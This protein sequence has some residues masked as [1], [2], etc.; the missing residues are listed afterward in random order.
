[1]RRMGGLSSLM[2]MLPTAAKGV[3]AKEAEKK[4][5]QQEAII[6]SMT[7]A[8]R[9]KPALLNASRKRRIAAGAGVDVPAVNRLLK[10]QEQMAQVM[11]KLGGM[12]KKKLMRAGLTG[13]LQGLF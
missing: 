9:R 2:G 3:D 4:L 10:Q 1:M 5:R 7:P 8:E 6:L 12:D 11:K 13:D